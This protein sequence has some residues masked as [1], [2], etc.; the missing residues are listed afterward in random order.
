MRIYEPRPQVDLPS[1]AELEALGALVRGTFPILAPLTSAPLRAALAFLA[2]SYARGSATFSNEGVA[3]SW[4]SRGNNWLRDVGDPGRVDFYSIMAGSIISGVMFRCSAEPDARV[5]DCE[6]ALNVAQGE[7]LNGKWRRVLA[8]GR[9]PPAAAPRPM[10]VEYL[11]H[12]ML[13]YHDRGDGLRRRPS[14]RR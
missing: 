5:V 10:P 11:E 7:R 9:L 2:G 1:P 13:D 8:S 14:I 6:L 3:T 4:T 12:D